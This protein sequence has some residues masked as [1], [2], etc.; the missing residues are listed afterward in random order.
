MLVN[1]ELQTII[2]F[3]RRPDTDPNSAFH[4]LAFGWQCGCPGRCISS[5]SLKYVF[6]FVN[7][8]RWSAYLLHEFVLGFE[9]I[10]NV[11]DDAVVNFLSLV[12][13][14][15][16]VAFIL[17]VNFADDGA[18]IARIELLVVFLHEVSQFPLV[19]QPVIVLIDFL[20][21]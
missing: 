6:Q 16:T 12:Q 10:R 4:R 1:S 14:Q 7:L 8:Y 3:G 19:N 2:I 18:G 11:V 9:Q 15:L 20:E 5:L 13:I 17:E 21:F